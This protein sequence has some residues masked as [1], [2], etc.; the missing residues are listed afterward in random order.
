MPEGR[1]RVYALARELGHLP[2]VVLDIARRLGYKVN[3]Q[4]SLIDA[5]ERIAVADALSQVP[6]SIPPATG[7]CIAA[8]SKL[9]AGRCPWC[10]R[11]IIRGK[12]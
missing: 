2:Q 12:G 8:H 1:I 11:G 9:L 5:E 4:L 10:G 3:N 6:S 7:P